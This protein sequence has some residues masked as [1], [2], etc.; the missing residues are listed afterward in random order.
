MAEQPSDEEI[1]Q[2][3]RRFASENNNRAW[4]L[5]ELSSASAEDEAEMLNAAHAAALH[6]SK[7]G[8]AL[9]AA[10]SDMLLGHVH[11]LLGN[12]SLAMR[13]A[14]SSFDHLTAHDCPDWELAFA[15]AILAN[16]ASSANDR[17]LHSHHY[18]LAESLGMA[19][20]DPEEREIFEATFRR[21][22]APAK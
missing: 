4:R 19:L 9:N 2:W 3:H 18:G 8:T 7:V 14:K 6:W 5:S 11:A 16:A 20:A 15:H 13:Y 12:G 10:R 1:R 17:D 22:P 21:I